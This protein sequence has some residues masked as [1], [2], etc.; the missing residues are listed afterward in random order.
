MVLVCSCILLHACEKWPGTSLTAAINASATCH[1]P[2][3]PASGQHIDKV[4]GDQVSDISVK[5]MVIRYVGDCRQLEL[6]YLHWCRDNYSIE[7]LIEVYLGENDAPMVE[8]THPS[9][10]TAQIYLQ[11]GNVAS[12]TSPAGAQLL[13]LKSHLPGLAPE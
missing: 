3:P 7:D 4:V 8:L 10:S 5:P 6:H 13:H 2:D 12:W 1:L 9:G 11:G